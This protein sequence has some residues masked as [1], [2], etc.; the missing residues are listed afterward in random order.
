MQDNNLRISSLCTS[1]PSFATVL[2]PN[3]FSDSAILRINHHDASPALPLYEPWP[4]LCI[5]PDPLLPS[6]P[7]NLLMHRPPNYPHRHQ[8]SHRA[9]AVHLRPAALTALMDLSAA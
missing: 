9:V 4:R 7:R 5:K 3:N 8:A 1:H 6:P 2:T